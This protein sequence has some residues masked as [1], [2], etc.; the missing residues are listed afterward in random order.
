MPK[1]C[2]TNEV[3]KVPNTLVL[4]EKILL[5]NAI[6]FFVHFPVFVLKFVRRRKN[7]YLPHNK[8]DFSIMCEIYTHYK[9][10]YIR[11]VENCCSLLL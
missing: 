10:S 8:D 3:Q 9:N 7:P 2:W 4:A 11:T 1:I 5:F 6:V